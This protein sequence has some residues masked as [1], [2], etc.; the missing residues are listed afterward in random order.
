MLLMDLYIF[1]E[2]VARIIRASSLTA[3]VL[4]FARQELETDPLAQLHVDERKI[5]LVNLE[6]PG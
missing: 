2:V 6:E 4:T 3:S 1:V 5:S